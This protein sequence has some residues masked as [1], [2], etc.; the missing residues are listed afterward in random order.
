M[1][2]FKVSTITKQTTNSLKETFNIIVVEIKNTTAEISDNG[3]FQ[4]TYTE[5]S[6]PSKPRSQEFANADSLSKKRHY[7]KY[8][9]LCG[10]Q[11]QS[12]LGSVNLACN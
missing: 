1:K 5:L 3:Q 10:Q 2:F 4:T 7:E 11:E 8:Y 6:I 12:T 9:K